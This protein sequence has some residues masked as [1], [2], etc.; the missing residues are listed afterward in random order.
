VNASGFKGFAKGEVLFLGASGSKRGLDD[1]EITFRFAASPNVA[2][3]NLGSIAGI[4]KEGWQYLWVRFIDDEDPTAK[5][6]I[7]R[8]VAA[9]VEQVYPYG[10]FANLGIGV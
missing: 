10:N 4:A 8:P 3:L 2:G 1:W 6:L 5:A 7:K 9:Y